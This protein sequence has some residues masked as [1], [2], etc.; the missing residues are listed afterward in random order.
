MEETFLQF[1][2]E[3]VKLSNLEDI[4]NCTPVVIE[5]GASGNANVVHIDADSGAKGFMFKDD[6][7]VD[8]VHHGL[9]SRW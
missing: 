2:V 8:K 4:V 6:V 1:E 3:V 9:E 7:L 5:V